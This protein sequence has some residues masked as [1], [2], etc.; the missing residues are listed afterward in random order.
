[1]D[2]MNF[3]SIILVEL[4]ASKDGVDCVECLEAVYSTGSQN[5]LLI[6]MKLLP[7]FQSTAC[8][9]IILFLKRLHLR[10]CC[11]KITM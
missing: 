4:S 2:I 8:S 1:M 3:K 9:T 11:L 6:L 7:N 10:D 5:V